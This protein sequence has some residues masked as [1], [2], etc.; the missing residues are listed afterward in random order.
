MPI[1]I[2]DMNRHIYSMR[3]DAHASQFICGAYKRPLIT[4]KWKHIDSKREIH[5]YEFLNRFFIYTEVVL[6]VRRQAI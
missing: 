1:F 4:E 2:Q 5:E 6:Y 3:S